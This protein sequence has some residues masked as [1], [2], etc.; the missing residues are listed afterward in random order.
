MMMFIFCEACGV[1][2]RPPARECARCFP[3]REM[4]RRRRREAEKACPPVAG[5]EKTS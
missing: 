4:E 1:P 3:V 2:V 5:R